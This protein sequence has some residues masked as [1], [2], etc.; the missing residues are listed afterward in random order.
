ARLAQEA[1]PEFVVLG[2]GRVEDLDRDRSQPFVLRAID[3]A[4]A[5]GSDQ[6]LDQVRPELGAGPRISGHWRSRPIVSRF[7]PVVG[8]RSAQRFSIST[9]STGSAS[10]KPKTRAKKK[11]TASCARRIVSARRKPWPSPSNARYANG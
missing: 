3:A 10:S 5:A 7:R 2:Q 4:H 8:R 1:L 6:I 11:A 9:G